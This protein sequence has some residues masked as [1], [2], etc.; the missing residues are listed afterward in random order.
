M[1]TFIFM[2]RVLLC[3]YMIISRR[4]K[5]QI[6]KK[7]SRALSQC[8]MCEKWFCESCIV[9]YTHACEY[10]HGNKICGRE[11]TM[12][13]SYAV[14]SGCRRLFCSKCAT[15]FGKICPVC[16]FKIYLVEK[17][18]P[19]CSVCLNLI[20]YPLRY[21][22]CESCGK[23][24]CE[25]CLPGHEV[26]RCIVCKRIICQDCWDG[27]ETFPKCKQCTYSRACNICG[28][29]KRFH[30]KGTVKKKCPVC[31]FSVCSHHWDYKK[32][33]CSRCAE[34][35]KHGKYPRRTIVRL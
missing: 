6:C 10:E 31:G 12:Q 22:K 16:A 32:E 21:V 3:F 25:S 30:R 18:S 4:E 34:R 14:C 11:I 9:L 2:M 33:L 23:V 19:V 20:E 27:N 8:K 28:T 29:G 1:R 17:P 15:E 5:C 35:I 26:K 24:I 13:D 7:V